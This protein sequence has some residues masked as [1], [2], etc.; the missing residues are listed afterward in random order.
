MEQETWKDEN[1]MNLYF[2]NFDQ[3][4]DEKDLNI[5]TATLRLYRIPTENSTK[6]AQKSPDCDTTSSE[7]EKLLRVSIY[8]YTRSVRKKKGKK[9]SIMCSIK[10]TL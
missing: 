3:N 4:S 8:W 6:L 1:I 5:A 7:E 10:K 9:F 2:N